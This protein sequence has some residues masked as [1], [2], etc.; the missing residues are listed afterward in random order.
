MG[1]THSSSVSRGGLYLGSAPNPSAA[2][3]APELLYSVKGPLLF[4]GWC[5]HLDTMDFRHV[6]DLL[7]MEHDKA[8]RSREL[9]FQ[10]R[11]PGVRANCLG[12]LVVIGRA[13]FEPCK[14]KNDLFHKQDEHLIPV[15]EK[16]GLPLAVHSVPCALSWGGRKQEPNGLHYAIAMNLAFAGLSP[17]NW[18]ISMGSVQIVRKDKKPLH[19]AHIEAL[20][21]YLEVIGGKPWKLS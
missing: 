17:N 4:T 14:L 5:T 20:Y 7:H 1:C 12:D 8:V 18:N 9:A 15:S 16:L 19:V 2:A 11:L 6:V 10:G 3:V 21:D 13:V